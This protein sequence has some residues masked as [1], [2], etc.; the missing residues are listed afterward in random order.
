MFLQWNVP[1]LAM[2]YM[3]WS[4]PLFLYSR[5]NRTMPASKTDA[6][7]RATYSA[8]SFSGTDLVGVSETRSINIGIE[9]SFVKTVVTRRKIMITIII[10]KIYLSIVKI[11]V[12]T[13]T[14]KVLL[15]AP[16][17][18]IYSRRMNIID[19]NKSFACYGVAIWFNVTFGE[20]LIYYNTLCIIDA[21]DLNRFS[22]YLNGFPTTRRY[23]WNKRIYFKRVSPA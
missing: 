2:L 15:L 20:R 11:N 9:Q 18:I 21:T 19:W 8:V 12:S 4:R 1:E 16:D 17:V 13:Y 23:V 6:A 3:L 5:N 14:R 22:L 10:K 7:I